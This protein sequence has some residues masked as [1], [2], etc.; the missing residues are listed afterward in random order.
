MKFNTEKLKEL[1]SRENL[2]TFKFA[3]KFSKITGRRISRQSIEN[4]ANGYTCPS[5]VNVLYLCKYYD[6]PITAFIKED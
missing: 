4:W 2:S 1:K 5:F 6:V 3:A